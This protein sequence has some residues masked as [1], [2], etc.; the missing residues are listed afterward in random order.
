MKK[1]EDIAKQLKDEI[2]NIVCVYAF[3]STGKTRLS[4]AYKDITKDENGNHAGMYYNAYSEDLFDWDN[5]E[6]NNNN[7]IRLNIKESSLNKHHSL[8]EEDFIRRELSAFKPGYEFKFSLYADTQRGISS[9][10]FS[11]KEKVDTN[12]PVSKKP[13]PT[14]TKKEDKNDAPPIKISR[15]EERIFI[16]CFFLALFKRADEHNAHFFI[17]DPVSSLDEN[18]IFFIADTIMQLVEDNFNKKRKSS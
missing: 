11:L 3:N 14:E 16:W 13:E 1:I 2:T 7:D 4:V 6:E 9:I 17:D 18:N 10:S 8:L 5:D 15:S 12:E